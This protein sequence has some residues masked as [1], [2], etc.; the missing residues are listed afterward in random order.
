MPD[1]HVVK[2]PFHSTLSE[3]A[4]KESVV[5]EAVDL[6]VCNS[7]TAPQYHNPERTW[8]THATN[9]DSSL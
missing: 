8:P 5:M 9:D 7:V 3:D 1:G 4:N 6:V 2:A